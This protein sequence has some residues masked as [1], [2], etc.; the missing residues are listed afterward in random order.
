MIHDVYYH[1]FRFRA[2]LQPYITF[3]IILQDILASALELRCFHKPV[4]KSYAIAEKFGMKNNFFPI[5][6]RRKSNLF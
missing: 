1:K 3:I 5:H 4:K 6:F 2:S